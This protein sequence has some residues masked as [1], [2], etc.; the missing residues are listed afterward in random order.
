MTDLINS[1]CP[2]AKQL[3]ED[4]HHLVLLQVHQQQDP[5]QTNI[6]RLDLVQLLEAPVATT[7]TVHLV[8]LSQDL[9]DQ[10]VL[11][12]LQLQ[13]IKDLLDL[14][15]DSPFLHQD[16]KGILL[17]RVVD[18]DFQDLPNNLKVI[19]QDRQEDHNQMNINQDSQDSLH[20][21]PDH[22]V[23]L[24]LVHKVDFKDQQQDLKVI[25]LVVSNQDSQDRRQ[26]HKVIRL[27]DHKEDLQDLPKG[28]KVVSLEQQQV[29]KDILQDS[30]AIQQVLQ[31]DNKASQVQRKGHK[32]FHQELV[33]NKVDFHLELVVSKED[34][35]DQQQD[36]KGIPLDHHLHKMDFHPA[37]QV[38]NQAF[39][40]Q[41]NKG[42]LQ[43]ELQ[44]V[45]LP[46]N[47][48]DLDFLPVLDLLVPL[49]LLVHLVQLPDIHLDD[50]EYQED[51]YL[52]NI[53]KVNQQLE[54]LEVNLD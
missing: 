29:L 27:E 4:L 31:V 34:F 36:P 14:K 41:V 25:L 48:L 53:Q 3:L 32:D 13:V 43:L 22:K 20:R 38:V 52:T 7:T 39:P 45:T 33:V 47:H 46:E 19:Q 54:V 9:V 49:R 28:L 44:V 50:R 23:F 12:D 8:E 10:V 16:R 40:V 51:L 2:V 18:K 30:K 5:N 15:V 11:E 37:L 26:V 21:H 24:L 42:F 35:Q 17:A 1:L 6:R